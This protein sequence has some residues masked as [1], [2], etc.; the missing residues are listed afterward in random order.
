LDISL[1]I[2]TNSMRKIICLLVAAAFIFN[3]R[4]AFSQSTTV[5]MKAM[6]GTAKLNG[7]STVPGHISEIDV[8]SNSLG[9]SSC[10]T[11]A[12]PYV[13]DYNIMMQLCPATISF[14]KLLLNGT[15]LTSVDI[16]YIKGGTTPV[17]YY[18]VHMEDVLVESV[19]E[20]ASSETAG[21]AATT[22]YGW[23]IVANTEWHY[24]F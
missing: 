21:T 19:Q 15:K 9:E 10:S 17:A 14:K 18:L 1:I 16:T 24:V 8:L 2:K 7:G 13:S 23:D 11:C 12:K 5:V 4:T 20:S 22:L 6:D 3:G